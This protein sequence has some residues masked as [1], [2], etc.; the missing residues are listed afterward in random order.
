MS[1]FPYSFLGYPRTVDL[2]GSALNILPS[3]PKE[4]LQRT[5]T[6]YRASGIPITKKQETTILKPINEAIKRGESWTTETYAVNPIQPFKEA[7]KVET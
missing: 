5:I 2:F 3:K 7:E 6:T 4:M 1:F